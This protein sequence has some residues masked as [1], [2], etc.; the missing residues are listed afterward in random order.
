MPR[1]SLKRNENNARSLPSSRWP[2]SDAHERR[3]RVRVVDRKR[4]RVVHREVEPRRR[5]ARR[6]PA[7]TSTEKDSA[8]TSASESG[9]NVDAALAKRTVAGYLPGFAN[10]PRASRAASA[11]SAVDG[12]HVED[13]ERGA[14]ADTLG[15]RATRQRAFLLRRVLRLD[16]RMPVDDFGDVR[17]SVG[18][19]FS[20]SMLS[21][22]PSRTTL[23]ARPRDPSCRG[24]R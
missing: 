15:V 14:H 19:F 10:S 1:R 5:R 6:R 23:S 4:G 2:R 11:G 8:R 7:G 16:G 22:I 13:L 17:S 9:S 24:L 21:V 18:S 3:E 20:N 12:R